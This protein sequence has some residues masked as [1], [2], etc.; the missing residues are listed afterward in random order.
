[1]KFYRIA[2]FCI[3]YILFITPGGA[4]PLKLNSGEW[5]KT[6]HLCGPFPLDKNQVTQ[7]HISEFET[8]FLR[9]HGGEANFD[10]RG[11]HSVNFNQSTFAWNKIT[12]QDS[13]VNLDKLISTESFV[14]AYAYT[15]IHSAVGGMF[16]L[17]LGTNDGG[18]LWLNG[19]RIWDFPGA[20]GLTPDDDLIPIVLK[21]GLNRIL[22]KIEERGNY[23]GFCARIVPFD[24]DKFV[25]HKS[26][27]EVVQ[28]NGNEAELRFMQN[29]SVIN[30]LFK[31][32]KLELYLD[33]LNQTL[34]W[35]KKWSQ[36]NKMNLELE[37]DDFQN[38]TLKINAAFTNGK[39]WQT[40][41]TFQAGHRIE[42]TLFENQKTD[43]SIVIGKDAS[44]SEFWAAKELQKWLNEISGADFPIK[45]DKTELGSNEI[46]VGY[47]KHA[48]ALLGLNSI[49]QENASETFTYRNVKANLLFLGGKQRGVMYAVFS[50]LENELGCRWYT[51]QVSS[52]PKRNNYIFNHLLHS[53]SPSIR[54]RNDFY[55]EAFDPDWA[56]R[57]KVNGAMGFRKQPGGVEA[58]WSVHTFYRFMPPTEFYEKHP[59]YYS[60]IDGKRIHDRAQLC[61]TNDDV[62][63]IVTARLRQTMKD[64]P[65]NLI[66]SVSQND[67]R[68]PCQ[69]SN[70]QAI[71]EKEGS[72]AGP[73]VRFV[74][75][76]AERIETEFPDKF[77]GTLA[78]QYTRKPLLHTRP[79]ENV[80]IRLCSIE[81]CFAHDFKNCPE[82][83]E[84]LSDLEGWAEI[85]PHLYIWDYVVNFSHYILPYPNFNVLQ[86][87]IKTFKANK[88]IGIMEQGAYQSRGGEFAELRAW[89]IAK[90]LWN[91]NANVDEVIDDFMYGY[92]GRSGQF[93][94]EYLNLLHDQVTEE[95]H[96]HLGLRPDDILFTD[97]FIREA[98]KIF[99][100]AETVAEN[101]LVRQRVELARLPLLYLKCK[102][103]P[104]MAKY[105]GTYDRFNYIVQ[106]EGITHFAEVGA[107]HIEE[108]HQQVKAAQ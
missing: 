35:E 82:N 83:K 27:F 55:F 105:D 7:G 75:K 100:R 43:Y 101:D 68:N 10:L 33:G 50:F 21:K 3:A 52:I 96:I 49:P 34:V 86:S 85:S 65:N 77:V 108:F 14:A 58:Y 8:D 54:V 76:V 32:V 87:N 31:S 63:E 93:V 104:V 45:D 62:L 25:D 57:N 56:A 72:E 80:V 44:E 90:L 19:E 23:W 18:R 37:R 17:A 107:P 67:W 36:K 64:F 4:Q 47:N 97:Q 61:L 41:I 106:R 22:L 89:V 60:L 53:E 39:D 28:I 91:D 84:F 6:W 24:I 74:N 46:I 78:Y 88:A 16:L 11:A 94:R 59:E 42:Y 103:H 98:G 102:R 5:L 38:Y 13:V 48:K 2:F 40:V 70:C 29:E 1:M 9:E 66:Y 26:L 81:C 71:V 20:R 92:Y 73:L 69:C 51:P 99:D 15:E 79:R 12:V 95:T 30:H